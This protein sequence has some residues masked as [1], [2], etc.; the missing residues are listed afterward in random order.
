MEVGEW[1]EGRSKE[2]TEGA[3]SRGEVEECVIDVSEG[4]GQGVSE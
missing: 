1:G 3:G 2:R 4:A